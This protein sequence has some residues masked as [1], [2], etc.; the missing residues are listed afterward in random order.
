MS[1]SKQV[2]CGCCGQNLGRYSPGS[3][4]ET[5]CPRCKAQLRVVTAD[6]QVTV[7]VIDLKT[8]EKDP[9]RAV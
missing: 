1:A 3:E 8:R 5:V 6:C 7:T 4:H 2:S 9:R